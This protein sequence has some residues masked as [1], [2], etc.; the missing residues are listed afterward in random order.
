MDGP[1]LARGLPPDGTLPVAFDGL[2]TAVPLPRLASAIFGRIDGRN[3]IGDIAD[4]LVAGGCSRE[5]FDREFQALA[6]AMQGIN[7]ML[8]AAPP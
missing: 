7:R 1:S 8:L 6:V 4:A 3:S 5:R 2:R